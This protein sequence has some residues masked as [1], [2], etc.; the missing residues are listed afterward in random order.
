MKKVKI[1]ENFVLRQVAGTWVVL[2]L[3]TETV[4]FSD[5]LKMNESGAFIWKE[6]ETGADREGLVKALTGEYSVTEQQAATDVNEFLD[7]LMQIGCIEE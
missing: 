6:L 4:D 7:K 2:P 3:A 5:M 1:K